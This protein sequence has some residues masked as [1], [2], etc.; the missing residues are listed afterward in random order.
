MLMTRSSRLRVRADPSRI[1]RAKRVKEAAS[2]AVYLFRESPSPLERLGAAGR[3]KPTAAGTL[4]HEAGT[5]G[6]QEQ[7]AEE[8]DDHEREREGVGAARADLV[9]R[10][11]DRPGLLRIRTGAPLH[12]RA[13]ILD[14]IRGASDAVGAVATTAAAA[15]A[16]A[17]DELPPDPD[18]FL[19]F[20]L[21]PPSSL[22]FSR[23]LAAIA[24]S[25]AAEMSSSA[26]E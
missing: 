21:V 5:A 10:L 25:I 12:H 11:G 24:A 4:L 20:V 22:L 2:V 8:P 13:R 18:E 16:A 1:A 9:H 7:E 26:L 14:V 23:S 3:R 19:P 17:A 15:S 6:D